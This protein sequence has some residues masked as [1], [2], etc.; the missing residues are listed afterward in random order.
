MVKTC[1]FEKGPGP[2]SGRIAA[3]PSAVT[4]GIPE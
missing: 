4:S 2:E 1:L 3:G